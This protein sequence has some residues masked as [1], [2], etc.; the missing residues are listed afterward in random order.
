LKLTNER[1]EAFHGLFATAELLVIVISGV[2]TFVRDKAT[3]CRAEDGLSSGRCSVEDQVG[4]YGGD[5][6]FT[7]D[8]LALLDGEGRCVI[9]EHQITLVFCD[10]L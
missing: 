3:P 9:T 4:G 5:D 10:Y 1:H 2:A 6:E 8:E 7:A